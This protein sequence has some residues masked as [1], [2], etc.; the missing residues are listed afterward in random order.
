MC[1]G[2]T[3]GEQFP[4][5]NVPSRRPLQ[6]QDPDGIHQFGDRPD[7]DA[8]AEGVVGVD[9]PA[10][11]TEG[12]GRDPSHTELRSQLLGKRKRTLALVG[13]LGNQNG[14]LDRRAQVTVLDVER[15]GH[16]EQYCTNAR[17]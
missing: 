10:Q 6:P 17:S 15:L 16:T 12:T 2:R 13:L 1:L 3:G 5:L 4:N 7:G 8:P 14:E 9:D 11:S